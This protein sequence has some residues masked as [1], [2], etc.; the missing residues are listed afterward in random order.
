M[1]KDLRPLSQLAE[2]TGPGRP[3]S[4]AWR[5]YWPWVKSRVATTNSLKSLPTWSEVQGGP[6]PQLE[7]STDLEWSPGWPPPTVWRVYQHGVMSREATTHSLKS[8][9]WP[10]V[11]SRESTTHRLKSLF[12]PGVK[13]RE[14]MRSRISFWP[15]PC[16]CSSL[17][18]SP[19]YSFQESRENINCIK[20]LTSFL[21]HLI[22][23]VNIYFRI[24]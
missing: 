13:S 21:V 1:L 15:T 19:M 16:W 14:A 4:L 23:M 17:N 2:S 10:G 20:F 12:W 3:P 5:V 9:F 11:K 24:S 6:H 7:E 8:L 22:T 18:T